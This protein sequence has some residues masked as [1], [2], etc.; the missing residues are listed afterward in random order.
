MYAIRSYY[1]QICVKTAPGAYVVEES[2]A[3]VVYEQP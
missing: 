2:L 1:G 3:R